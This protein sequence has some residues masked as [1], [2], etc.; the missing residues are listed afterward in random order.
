MSPTRLVTIIRENIANYSVEWKK[1]LE[2][3]PTLTERNRII[4]Y[5][6]WSSIENS[7]WIHTSWEKEWETF[8][9]T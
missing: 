4:L 8:K 9:N 7:H 5:K 1:S 2:R 3:I 6:P